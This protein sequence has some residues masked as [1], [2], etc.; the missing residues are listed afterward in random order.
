MPSRREKVTAHTEHL[1]DAFLRLQATYAILDPLL[2]DQAL[3]VR[4]RTG[5]AAQGRQILLSALLNSCVLEAS[6]LTFD[7]DPRT[8]SLRSL[9]AALDDD[10]LRAELCEAYAV[11]N[12]HIEADDPEVLRLIRESEKR[13]EE[14]RRSEFD[15]LVERFRSAWGELRDS[16]TLKAFETLRDKVIAHNEIRHDGN[17]YRTFDIASLGLKFGDLRTIVQSLEP[18]VDSANLVFRAT[19]FAFDDSDQQ[20]RSASERF[21]ALARDG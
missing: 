17:K 15:S 18:I 20:L 16:P 7:Q 19:S 12:V 8:P 3:V 4:W 9:D 21:W 14:R 1:L 11:W 2:F 5:P 13:D 10:H 6:K